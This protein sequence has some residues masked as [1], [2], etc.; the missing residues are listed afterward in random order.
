MCVHRVKPRF[1]LGLRIPK[2]L[3]SGP[4]TLIGAKKPILGRRPN[5]GRPK[6]R[7]TSNDIV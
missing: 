1:L 5:I 6:I 7:Y 4:M 2:S 3:Q